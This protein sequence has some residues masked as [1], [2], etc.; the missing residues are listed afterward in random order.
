MFLDNMVECSDQEHS[1][2]ETNDDEHCKLNYQLRDFFY[3]RQ[4]R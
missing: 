1:N 4:T 2:D 3:C